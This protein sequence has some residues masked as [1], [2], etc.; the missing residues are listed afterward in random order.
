VPDTTYSL[1]PALATS[2]ASQ[3]Q[4]WD[5]SGSSRR[6]WQ[7]DA[8]LWTGRDEAMWLGWL[9]SPARYAA[10]VTRYTAFASDIAAQG[11]TDVAV[12][13]MGGS[14]LAPWVLGQVFGSRPGALRLHVLDSTDPAQIRALD[15]ALDLRHTLFVLASKSGS[16]LE[17]NV[18]RDY[19]LARLKRVG[20]TPPGSHFI[21]ITDPGSPVEQ[22]ARADGYRA[23]FHG[24]KQIG[25]RFS[26]LSPFGLVPA[27]LI[28]LDL[29]DFLTRARAMAAAC[30]PDVPAAVNPGVLLGTIMGI[31]GQ[32]GRDKLTVVAS[33]AFASLGAWLEQMVAES[34]GKGGVGII[35]VAGEPLAGPGEYGR[36][37]LF[38]YTRISRSADAAT[39]E[40]MAAL[41]RS[42]EPVV[43][44]DV[45][46]T[47]ELGAEFYR[48]EMATAVA[49]ALLSVNPFDQPDVEDAKVLT[50][51]LC[52]EY[53]ASGILPAEE[54]IGEGFGLLL[55][56]DPA[57]TA[58]LIQRAGNRSISRLLQAHLARLREDDYFA[59]LA[60]LPML[61]RVE[62]RTE[63]IRRMV[64]EARRVAT[65]VG[66]GPRFQH[67]TGQA[68]KGG[69]D[70]G[71]FLQLTCSDGAQDLAVPAH[72]YTFG[73]VKAAQAR[74]DFGALAARGRRALRVHLGEDVDGGLRT[75]EE[76]IRKGLSR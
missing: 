3:L 24:E 14:S 66:F 59:L 7:R 52:A 45:A 13:G 31:L 27:A 10:E 71:V 50:R 47:R 19:F 60:Y 73:I 34:T 39:E 63:E 41:E 40:R 57:N 11:F 29:P 8:A 54:P 69:P 43:R 51:G 2:V 42:G 32:H 18:L 58:A 4:A 70:S 61:P 44:I 33:P 72:R 56:A 21:A 15:A 74:G 30:G 46:D 22:Q 1:P 67:S 16:T 20:V 6:L 75:L 5:A 53:E 17:P 23:V 49:G 35:P 64:F 55:F 26:A 62:R 36:D 25:G 12:L 38:V 76:L 68:Y 37:R 65:S 48:W 28:G 9:D